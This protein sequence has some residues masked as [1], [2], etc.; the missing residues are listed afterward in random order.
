MGILR[1]AVCPFPLRLSQVAAVPLSQTLAR[2]YGKTVTVPPATPIANPLVIPWITENQY[3]ASIE[4][5]I[6]AGHNGL[7]GIRFMKGD[8][9]FLPWGVNSWIIANDLYKEFG[10]GGEVNTTD[11]KI[12]AYNLGTYQH[13]FY[14]LAS[15]IS[16][17][18]QQG[19]ALGD[20][21][22]ILATPTSS[23][24]SDPLSP[25][26]ILGSD[27]TEL[28]YNGDATAGGLVEADASLA[29]T[30]VGV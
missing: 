20:T 9:Q 13:S 11:L 15:I 3:L 16:L 23:G 17:P 2:T 6:P 4:L 21:S 7:T 19:A 30:P 14:L 28:L 5:I 10:V 29:I 1:V 18:N 8:I 26:S 24:F 12:Q 22:Q 25:D 27:T